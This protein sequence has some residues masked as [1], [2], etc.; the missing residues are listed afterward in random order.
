VNQVVDK[1][2]LREGRARLLL[3]E[4]GNALVPRPEGLIDEEDDWEELDQLQGLG[5]GKINLP[6]W[7]FMVLQ[8]CCTLFL[9]CIYMMCMLLWWCGLRG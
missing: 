8:H 6:W 3:D 7:L 4:Q 9:A 1:E 5:Q 2:D